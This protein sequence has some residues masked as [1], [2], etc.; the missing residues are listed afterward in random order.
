MQT[1]AGRITPP[2]AL[3][4]QSTTGWL[5]R[6]ELS[7]LLIRQRVARTI[8]PVCGCVPQ[9]PERNRLR[10]GTKC[11]DRISLG[12]GT[13][14]SAPRNGNRA[15]PASSHG[16]RR[17]RR[18]RPRVGRPESLRDDFHR[19]FR[20]RRSVAQ[21]LVASLGRPGGNV[22]G[23]TLFGSELMAKRVELLHEFLPKAGTIAVLVSADAPA[24]AV[25]VK[26]ARWPRFSDSAS[27]WRPVA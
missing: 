18:N 15:G 21:G 20:R 4:C 13:I 25:Y 14:R 7:G 10:R 16:D 26:E 5:G 27:L 6:L 8:G 12:R 9:G 3:G 17:G 19:L 11:G 22:T 2:I 24:D 1:S 23:V